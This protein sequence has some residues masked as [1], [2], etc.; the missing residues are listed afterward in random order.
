[1]MSMMPISLPDVD[2]AD[3]VV[4][5][6]S[7][8]P[9]A[10]PRI[11]QRDD[12]LSERLLY[13]HASST[14]FP[15]LFSFEVYNQGLCYDGVKFGVEVKWTPGVRYTDPVSGVWNLIHKYILRMVYASRVRVYARALST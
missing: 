3:K 11:Y 4:A 8:Y 12:N 1:M 2:D 15:F 14:P 7:S 10:A 5:E 9:R 13:T 6:L